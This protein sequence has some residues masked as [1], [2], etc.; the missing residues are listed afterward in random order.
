MPGCGIRFTEPHKDV[1]GIDQRRGA[2]DPDRLDLV[3]RITQPSGIGEQDRDPRERQ[4]N[5]NMVASRS[6]HI[7]DDCPLR[8][9][10]SIDKTRFPGIRRAGDDDPNPIL[11]RLDT[12]PA[13]PVTQFRSQRPTF[14]RNRLVD[15]EIVLVIVNRALS[16]GG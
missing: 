10:Y 13:E 12:W 6:G 14:A 3:L 11:Q 2:R 5:L 9:S 8:A 4:W 15:S 7:R 16:F 1:G